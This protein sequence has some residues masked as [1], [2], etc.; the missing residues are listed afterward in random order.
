MTEYRIVAIIPARY[1]SARFP[2]KLLA[3][4]MGKTVLQRTYENALQCPLLDHVIVATDS[5]KIALHVREFGG[6]VI[7]TSADCPSGSD[8]IAE[9]VKNSPELTE[10][11]IIIN[12]QGDEP[13]LHPSTV[14]KVIQLLLDDPDANMSTAIIRLNNDEE[15]QDPSVVKCVVDEEGYALYF[16][17]A[18]IPHGKT[19]AFNS[20]TVYYKHIGIY[21]YRREFLLRFAQLPQSPLQKAE[22]LEQ[23]KAMEHGYRIKTVE[24]EHDVIGINTVED[25]KKKLKELE[26][27]QNISLSQAESVHL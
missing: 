11:E 5:E 25:L 9:A 17:R 8:R 16:S 2:G 20:E 6:E 10:C 13:D 26:C 14:E 21:G 12:I 24:V 19:G 15:A 22:D 4:M 1:D 7:M 18:L 27:K 3:D 23:L